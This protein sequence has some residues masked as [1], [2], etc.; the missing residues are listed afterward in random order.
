M[1]TPPSQHP[2]V[3]KVGG[4]LYD[5]PDLGFRLKSFLDG[6]NTLDRVLVPG[7]GRSADVVRAWD[8]H[9]DLGEEASHWLALRAL[10]FNAHFLASLLPE[11]TVIQHLDERH[12]LAASGRIPILDMYAWALADE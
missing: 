12:G 8:Q 2:V 9:H 1:T 3:V 11:A 7:G 5:L 10:T 4:S 6:L